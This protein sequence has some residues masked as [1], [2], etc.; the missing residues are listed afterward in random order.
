MGSGAL[1][2]TGVAAATPSP[3]HATLGVG[4]SGAGLR[5]WIAREYELL[6]EHY[7]HEDDAFFK[8]NALFSTLNG[9]L[10]AATSALSSAQ[11][12]RAPTLIVVAFS[13]VICATWFVTLVRLRAW[14]LVMTERIEELEVA[15][16][17]DWP[18]QVVRSPRLRID[19]EHRIEQQSRELPR[20][21]RRMARLPSS[22]VMLLLPAAVGA[23][24]IG[25]GIYLLAA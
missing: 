25:Q 3:P 22:Q 14:R 24:W 18:D 23:L 9:G 20:G 11:R 7:F 5:D 15:I 17:A 6:S 19:W 12:F 1:D 4:G 8:A 13:L 16:A 10:L 2:E 21:I